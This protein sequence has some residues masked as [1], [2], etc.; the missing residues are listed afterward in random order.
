MIVN[1]LNLKQSQKNE[2]RENKGEIDLSEILSVLWKGYLI[3]FTAI[4]VFVIASIFY[5]LSLPNIYRSEVLLSP[6]AENGGM[7]I[8]GQ[9]GGLAALA[10]VNLGEGAGSKTDL[11]IEILKS[12]EFI[13]RFIAKYD[14]FVPVMASKGWSLND[15]RLLIDAD[16][17]D[18]KNI[19]W[20]RDV[21]PPFKPKP[22]LLETH[23]QFMRLFKVSHDKTSNMVKLAVE[24]YS[25]YLAQKWA[26][27]LVKEINEDMRRRELAEAQSSIDYLHNQITHTSIADVKVMLFSLIEEQ[28]KTVML[29]N[30]RDEYV[31]KTVDPAVVAENRV[32]PSRVLIVV[33]AAILG[34]LFGAMLVLKRYFSARTDG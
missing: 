14:L 24:H 22:S 20:V 15:N 27:M 9:L 4:G 29:A 19:Q 2:N 12:R 33:L 1:E 3:I 21:K 18:E 7:Q 28:T 32:K 5:A 34:A 13:G 26:T 10:G 8:P 23:E 17:Y 6:V 30:V 16:I 31:L 25:P 11:A